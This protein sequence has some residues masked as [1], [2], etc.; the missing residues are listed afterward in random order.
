MQVLA[1]VMVEG[2]MYRLLFATG[3]YIATAS[4]YDAAKSAIISANDVI[5]HPH[6]TESYYLLSQYITAS[7]F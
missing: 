3:L 4:R 2:D 6:Y 5:K 7:Q 1:T